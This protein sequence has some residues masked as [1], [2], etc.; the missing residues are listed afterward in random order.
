MRKTGRKEG[1]YDKRKEKAEVAVWLLEVSVAG[2]I[3]RVYRCW[4]SASHYISQAIASLA[5]R[6]FAQLVFAD[7]YNHNNTAD[8]C[9]HST[10]TSACTRA[11]FLS[12]KLI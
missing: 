3:Q 6:H 9:Q 10:D 1:Y 7:V 4:L 12:K 2:M 11:R 5:E 8:V